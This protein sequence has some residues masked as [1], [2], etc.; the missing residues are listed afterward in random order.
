MTNQEPVYRQDVCAGAGGL[1][2]LLMQGMV[3]PAGNGGSMGAELRP[4]GPVRHAALARLCQPVQCRR[5][6]PNLR[7]HSG[8]RVHAGRARLLKTP[9]EPVHWL[10][11]TFARTVAGEGAPAVPGSCEGPVSR[12]EGACVP[13]SSGE[14]HGGATSVI[15]MYVYTMKRHCILHI[16][17]CS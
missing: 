6:R 14:A 17:C 10:V 9:P 2:S 5:P 3:W 16:A 7:A 11:K 13:A 15:H 4:L 8:C 12:V 1:V